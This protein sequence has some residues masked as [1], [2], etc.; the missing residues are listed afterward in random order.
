M[1]HGSVSRQGWVGRF[2]AALASMALF[3]LLQAGCVQAPPAQALPPEVATQIRALPKGQRPDPAT[4]LAADTIRA[5]LAAFEAGASFLTTRGALDR[6]GRDPLGYPDNSQ[7]VMPARQMDAL[8]ARTHGNVALIEQE[9]GL[10][11]GTW[12]GQQLVRIDIPDP[13]AVNLRMASGNEM[14]ANALWLPGGRLPTGLLEA[15]VNRLRPSQY[16]EV[17]L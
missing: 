3:A 8:L 17:P 11:P 5:H 7:F 13:R 12:T 16:R 15:V 1:G 14:G 4:Y 2:A 9:L 10:P 6:F